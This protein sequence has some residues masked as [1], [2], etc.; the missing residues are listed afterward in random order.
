MIIPRHVERAN[1]IRSDLDN[2]N[3]KIHIHSSKTKIN[4]NTDIYL[5]DTYGKNKSFYPYVKMYF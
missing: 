5:V 2:L 1:T 4:D 3:L